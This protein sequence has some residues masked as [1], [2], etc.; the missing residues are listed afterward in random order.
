ML[1]L[2]NTN[3]IECSIHGKRIGNSTGGSEEQESRVFAVNAAVYRKPAR[4]L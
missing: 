4:T 1:D 2:F 3:N